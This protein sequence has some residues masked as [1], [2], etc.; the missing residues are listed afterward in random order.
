MSEVVADEYRDDDEDWDEEEDTEDP[1]ESSGCGGCGCRGCLFWLLG[2]VAAVLAAVY[3]DETWAWWTEPGHRDLVTTWLVDG[4]DLVTTWLVDSAKF[5]FIGFAVSVLLLVVGLVI[6]GKHDW[7]NKN[8]KCPH[9]QGRL[10]LRQDDPSDI[11]PNETAARVGGFVG[12]VAGAILSQGRV[13]GREIGKV[14]GA[15]A[16]MGAVATA[17]AA[18]DAVVG[19]SKPEKPI[20]SCK[21]C[22][23]AFFRK[24]ADVVY[25]QGGVGCLGP[26]LILA[27]I[28]I[29]LFVVMMANQ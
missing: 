10:A 24:D 17:Q 21:K 8:P 2:L 14:A 7:R 15:V 20:A 3:A 1:A 19:A 28:V 12:E 25:N 26:A 11:E 23:A 5:P 13:G 27:G 29:V 16:G 4:V 6:H 9:C 22:G 18:F